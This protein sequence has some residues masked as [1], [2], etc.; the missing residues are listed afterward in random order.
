MRSTC[1][2]TLAVVKLQFHVC[3][4]QVL[5]NNFRLPV[6]T[7]SVLWQKPSFRK[8]SRIQKIEDICFIHLLPLPSVRIQKEFSRYTCWTSCS[9]HLDLKSSD[10]MHDELW[11]FPL[12]LSITRML[13]YSVL[14]IESLSWKH[15]KTINHQELNKQP[16]FL[17]P[18]CF[19][20]W[21]SL[22]VIHITTG[23]YLFTYLFWKIK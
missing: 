12:H 14:S 2:D 11:L 7:L 19:F 5:W 4:V 10:N 13:C 9:Q 6:M 18:L 3:S 21:F 20:C 22:P 8:S 1:G 23:I 16:M 15:V 17:W